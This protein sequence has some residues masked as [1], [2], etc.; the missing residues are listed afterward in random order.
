M[1]PFAWEK[2][3]P[4]GLSWDTPIDRT[5]LPA[6]LDRMVAAHGAKPAISFRQARLGFAE[7]GARADRFAA[8]L[9]RRGIGAGGTVALYLP[10][11]P[12][13]PIA[14]FGVLRT[15]ARV[16]HLSPLDAPR[17]LARK[18]QDSGARVIVTTDLAPVL[19][20]ALSLLQDGVAEALIVGSDSAWGGETGALPVPE[21]ARI[22]SFDAVQAEAPARWPEVSPGDLALLQYTGGTT[23][24]PRAAMLTHANITASVAIYGAWNAGCGRAAQAG[25]R[26]IVVLPL[27]HI[28][29]LSAVML[30]ALVSGTELLLHARF[31]ADTVLRDI[32]EKRAAAFFGVP[33]MVIALANHPGVERRDLSSLRS[34]SSGGASMPHEV[35][36]RWTALTGIR[37][38]GG[39]G[40]TET[41]PAGTSMIPGRA[42]GPGSIGHPLPG[43][44]M[45]IVA[46][47]DPHRVLPPGETGEIRIRGPNVTAGYWNR[48]EETAAA[49]A[50]G[51]FLTGDIGFMD[52]D[53]AFTLVDRKKDMIISGGFN[54]YPRVIEDAI[55]EHPAVREAAV[56]GVADAYRG[57]LAK[58]FIV[59][60]EEAEGFTLEELRAFLADKLGRHELPAALE[61]R[62]ALPRTPV[63]KLAK[64]ELVEEE[65]ARMRETAGG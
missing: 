65:R 40:M 20:N 25:D 38:G 49:F 22:V 36:E 11:T 64:R 31:D 33:T 16:V 10:N 56:I 59:L 2:A 6:L 5:T 21:D 61:F 24:L 50:D 15:G 57:Q 9:M 63:G 7:F 44:E 8:G 12:Y 37:L 39:W 29:A 4:P 58:A 41:S 18:M 13:H 51:F 53:G 3:Y 28:Y 23:G 55:Y 52:A 60:R 45:Q 26:T 27:F 32:E 35:A 43:I 34:C 46:L 48:R 47:E 14:F 17:A 19:P 30:R 62:D 54:V 1:R 42:Y